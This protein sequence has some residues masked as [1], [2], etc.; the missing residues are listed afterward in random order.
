MRSYRH[1]LKDLKLRG[2]RR[3]KRK[4]FWN[5]KNAYKGPRGYTPLALW[6]D[7][8]E[9]V[10]RWDNTWS[11]FKGGQMGEPYIVVLDFHAAARDGAVHPEDIIDLSTLEKIA[12]YFRGH[13]PGGDV[14]NM[15]EQGLGICWKGW[16]DLWR[17]MFVVGPNGQRTRLLEHLHPRDD[18]QYHPSVVATE[19]E[20]PDLPLS[21]SSSVSS[22]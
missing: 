16:R 5:L 6:T 18:W 22:M 11:T 1:E 14:K 4:L 19:L 13:V 10:T 17:F 2:A 3:F 7:S 20:Q 15:R 21:Q 9:A 12:N 8:R